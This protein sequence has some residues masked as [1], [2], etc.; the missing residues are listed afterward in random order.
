SVITEDSIFGDSERNELKSRQLELDD[1]SR[2][3]RINENLLAYIAM[4]RSSEHLILIRSISDDGGRTTT[5]SIYWRMF[6]NPTVRKF[7]AAFEDIS[8]FD[9]TVA[10]L[11]KW[12]RKGASPKPT[13]DRVYEWLRQTTGSPIAALRDGAWPALL[14]DNASTLSQES[15]EQ[16]FG[17]PLVA[18]VSQLE[19][20]AACPFKHFVR[21]GL[22]LQIRQDQDP[23]DL[24]MGNLYHEAL[25]KIVTSTLQEKLDW[26]NLPEKLA[27]DLIRSCTDEVGQHLREELMLSS[28]R[29]RHLLSWITRTLEKVTAA[30]QAAAR[31]GQFRPVLAELAFGIGDKAPAFEV[32][33]PKGHKVELRGKID[34]VDLTRGGDAFS[35]IDYKTSPRRLELDRVWHGLSLQLLI[36]M[37]VMQEHGRRI[38]KN[39]AQAAAG[40]YVELVRRLKSVDDPGEAIGPDDPLFNLRVKP[41]GIVRQD[42][43]QAFDGELTPGKRSDVLNIQ[44]NKDGSAHQTSDL[45]GSDDIEALLNHVREKVGELADRI[46]GGCIEAHPYKIGDETPCPNCDYRSVCRF[47]PGLNRYLHLTHLERS[48]VLEQLTDSRN[49]SPRESKRKSQ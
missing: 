49:D 18:S 35:V 20:F 30:Q 41:R 24:D 4:T 2:Q 43:A 44:I 11:M 17:R 37:M 23:T 38:W 40:L 29:N 15:A 45:V 32:M 8:S 10:R 28:A 6:A 7:G 16:L 5:P 13:A 14:Y 22:N 26:A 47:Q 25:Q 1:D 39:Q 46:I 3:K 36:Y 48:A 34:R 33:T 12:V 19:T 21:Y 42:F 31:R 9:Q 27:N